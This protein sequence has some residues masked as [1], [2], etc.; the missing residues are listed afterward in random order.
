MI[1]VSRLLQLLRYT[2]VREISC[3]QCSRLFLC[4]D[5]HSLTEIGRRGKRVANIKTLENPRGHI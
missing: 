5:E 3:K 1:L 4:D 2:A